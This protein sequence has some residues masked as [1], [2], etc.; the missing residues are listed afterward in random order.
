MIL[1]KWP[2]KL[3]FE[4]FNPSIIKLCDLFIYGYTYN[5]LFKMDRVKGQI[6]KSKPLEGIRP[7]FISNQSYIY[8]VVNNTKIIQ[9][10]NLE[11]EIVSE[12]KYR[13][14]Y[15]MVYFNSVDSTI[16]LK[17]IKSEEIFVIT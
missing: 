3:H 13:D 17:C 2:K 9:I 5:L 6:V 1:F 4:N 7:T 15:D 10:Y 8:A 12:I 14:I 16:I 11:F